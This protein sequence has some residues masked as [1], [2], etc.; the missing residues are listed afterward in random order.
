MD[1]PDETSPFPFGSSEGA[2]APTAAE[3]WEAV[4]QL[5]AEDHGKGWEMVATGASTHD[6]CS[7]FPPVLHEGLYLRNDSLPA[8]APPVPPQEQVRVVEEPSSW[9]MRYEQVGEMRPTRWG[10]LSDSARRLIGSGIEVIRAKISLCKGGGLGL[11]AGGGVWSFMA[12]AGFVGALMYMKRRHR[13][14]KE[15][16]LL[17]LQEKD[18]VKI[19]FPHFRL[20]L[21]KQRQNSSVPV[22]VAA[23]SEMAFT[24]G[25]GEQPALGS[26]KYLVPRVTGEAAS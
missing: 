6:D 3:S 14:E 17:L 12:V 2:A 10:P 23:F 21:G 25:K 5:P 19:W 15:L 13:R 8:L 1:V 4:A 18:Q 26:P 22:F 11:V 20:A 9:P 16:L 7:I 24:G